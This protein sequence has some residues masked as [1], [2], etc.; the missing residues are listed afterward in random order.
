MTKAEMAVRIAVLERKLAQTRHAHAQAR[1]DY[2][3]TKIER[4]ELRVEVRRYR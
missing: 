1:A 2:L 4:D 3:G